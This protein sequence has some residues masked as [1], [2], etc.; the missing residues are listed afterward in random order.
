M[1]EIRGGRPGLPVPNSPYGLC[2][3]ETTLNSKLDSV[4]LHVY[5][6]QDVSVSVCG[7]GRGGGG[8][9][10]RG[11]MTNAVA[12]ADNGRSQGL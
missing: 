2:G 5:W 1:G 8:G 9:D 11:R 3:R 10:T 4:A 7:G 6:K 12:S